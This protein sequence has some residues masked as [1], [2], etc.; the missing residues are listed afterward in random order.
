[1]YKKYDISHCTQKEIDALN[2]FK[3]DHP[4]KSVVVYYTTDGFVGSGHALI[5]TIDKPIKKDGRTHFGR[6]LDITDYDYRINT[7]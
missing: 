1:M 2:D 4:T 6:C 3:K 5:A 7:F